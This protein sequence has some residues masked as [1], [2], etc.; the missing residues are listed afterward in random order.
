[1]A[2][3]PTL[4]HLLI[5]AISAMTIFHRMIDTGKNRTWWPEAM[6]VLAGMNPDIGWVVLLCA[7]IFLYLALTPS[8]VRTI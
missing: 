6:R 5:S 8:R 4:L 3:G 1:V 7:A 2:F